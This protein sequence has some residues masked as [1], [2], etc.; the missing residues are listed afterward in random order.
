MIAVKNKWYYLPLIFLC[1]FCMYKSYHFIIHDYANYYFGSLF[2]QKGIF[3]TAIYFPYYFN[4]T[5]TSFGYQNIFVSY[6]PNTP[7]LAIFFWVFSFLEI[8]F[9]KLLFNSISSILFVATI[10]RL[11]TYFKISKQNILLIPI[12]FFIPIKNNLLFGQVYFLLFFLLSEG[13]LAYKK[14]Q[15]K[16]LA[17]F[18]SL[19]IFLKV[20]P[21]LLVFFLLVKKEFKAIIYIAISCIVLFIFSIS[22]TGL[23]TWVFYISSVI[24]RA[25]NGEIAGAFVD[26]YQSFFMFCKRLFV[27]NVTYNS[28]PILDAPKFFCGLI[29]FIKILVLTLGIFI[30]KNTKNSLISFSFWVLASILI[31]PYGSTYS[32]LILI[33]LFFALINKSFVFRYKK[34][35]LLFLFLISNS[36][37]ITKVEF[38]LNYLRLYF[39][40]L[41]FIVLI[42]HFRKQIPLKKISIAVF[43]FSIGI[44]V[45]KEQKTNFKT[46]LKTPILTYDYQLKNDK[47]HYS[48]WNENGENHL[49]KEFKHKIVDSTNIKIVDNQIFYKDDQITF[50]DSNKKKPVIIN[51]KKVIF[52]SDAEIGIG[53]YSIRKLDL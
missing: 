6:A 12:L 47:I 1:I 8:E 24:N 4:K 39:L 31:S 43:L 21:I 27:C 42:W 35:G 44:T 49:T 34:I 51:D 38:P 40:T 2:L 36:T 45:F 48:F 30:T 41:F 26:N 29:I 17:I 10:S 28:N 7:F 19:A 33:F 20:F 9:S 15:Y 11:A 18:W 53:F 14:Q 5:I 25:N 37:V 13:F 3:N 16:T 46:V 32:F 50:D 23:D 52:L 22:I